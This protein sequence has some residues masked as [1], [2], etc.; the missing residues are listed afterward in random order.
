MPDRNPLDPRPAHRLPQ[1]RSRLG[2]S[3]SGARSC[4]RRPQPAGSGD[5]EF[6]E[7][8]EIRDPEFE[9]WIRDQ[10]MLDSERYGRRRDYLL[11]PAGRDLPG[12]VR[13]TVGL[14]SRLNA[15]GES[16]AALAD[17]MLNLV[18]SALLG[19]PA[20]DVIDLRHRSELGAA[21]TPV[22]GLDWR[23]CVASSVWRSRVRITLT[24]SDGVASRLHWTDDQDLR[25]RRVLRGG[26]A[27]RRRVRGARGRFRPGPDPGRRGRRPGRPILSASTG[28]AA[29]VSPISGRP[30]LPSGAPMAVN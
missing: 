17:V 9:H 8:L 6:L 14:I 13:P 20:I 3:R 22:E 23:L 4:E 16:E 21:P 30:K 2:R 10:R 19:D 12:H 5:V 27:C 1:D 25:R 29:N 26:A 7:G 11:A 24:L 28:L 18:A 15:K